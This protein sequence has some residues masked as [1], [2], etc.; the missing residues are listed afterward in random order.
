MPRLSQV[1]TVFLHT[2]ASPFTRDAADEEDSVDDGI[3][4]LKDSISTARLQ[5]LWPTCARSKR[6]TFGFGEQDS[7]ATPNVLMSVESVQE[8]FAEASDVERPTFHVLYNAAA[9]G[10]SSTFGAGSW[11]HRRVVPRYVFCGQREVDENEGLTGLDGFPC[12]ASYPTGAEPCSQQVVATLASLPL[13]DAG[14]VAQLPCRLVVEVL[15]RERDERK[16]QL[17]MQVLTAKKVVCPLSPPLTTPS[18]LR[19][20]PRPN[21]HTS[22]QEQERSRSVEPAAAAAVAPAVPVQQ[23][24]PGRQ[25]QLFRGEVDPTSEL[26]PRQKTEDEVDAAPAAAGGAAGGAGGGASAPPA[27]Q[28]A[29]VVAAAAAALADVEGSATPTPLLYSC[30][31]SFADLNDA[32][33]KSTMAVVAV[34]VDLL[35]YAALVFHGPHGDLAP[36]KDWLMK[37][38]QAAAAG[39]VSLLSAPSKAVKP[40]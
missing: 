5:A 38:A 11:S 32:L 21:A 35:F 19:L 8:H 28:P 29:S 36:A 24:S 14:N 9:H 16:K 2:L 27:A 34:R 37:F 6:S 39:N 13:L 26:Q 22:C 4:S 40:C 30:P 7:G 15:D 33:K 17:R 25:A 1:T 10:F 23:E 31:G 3:A 18:L 20:R 12:V